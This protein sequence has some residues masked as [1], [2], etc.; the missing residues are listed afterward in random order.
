MP[1][2]NEEILAARQVSLAIGFEAWEDLLMELP[3]RFFDLEPGDKAQ[4]WWAIL[5]VANRGERNI[6]QL[7][8]VAMQMILAEIEAPA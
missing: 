5:K 3:D 4:I 6:A 2:I 8:K 1:E 7:G